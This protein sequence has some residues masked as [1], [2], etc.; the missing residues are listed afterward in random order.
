MAE[1]AKKSQRQRELEEKRKKLEA[2]RAA[3]KEP[4]ASSSSKPSA[5]PAPA[6]TPSAPDLK[7]VDNVEDLLRGLDA[8]PCAHRPRVYLPLLIPYVCRA[9]LIS[10]PVPLPK[11]L[12]DSIAADVSGA[13]T[14]S[15]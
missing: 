9:P 1:D 13:H 14:R 10:T 3:A 4:P 12:P 15:L 5:T 7:K 2:I 11:L 8:I 6:P